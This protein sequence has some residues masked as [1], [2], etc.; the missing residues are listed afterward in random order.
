M[1][2]VKLNLPTLSLTE[3]VQLARSIVTAMTGNVNFTTPAPT[4][5]SLT[6]AANDVEAKANAAQ[7]KRQAA[8]TATSIQNDAEAALD[9]KLGQMANYVEVASNGEEAKI[10]SAGIDVR[11]PRAPVGLL[12]AVQALAA[13]GGDM[14]GECDLNWQPVPKS[15]NY[16]IEKSPDPITASSWQQVG[17]STK[18]KFTVPGLTSGTKYWF[19][20]AAI[21]T[22]GQAPW[23]DPATA[24]AS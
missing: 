9:L 19:R 3:K 8:Q 18:S 14:N 22:A 17:F 23:S 2:K 15:K 12:P 13:T 16:V 24:L 6:S 5:A 21:G 10:E 11:S 4:L 7:V 20:V 1:A